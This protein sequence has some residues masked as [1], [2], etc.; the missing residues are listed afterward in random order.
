MI[1]II[2]GTGKKTNYKHIKDSDPQY[3]KY[4]KEHYIINLKPE[5]VLDRIDNFGC[6][7]VIITGGEPMVQHKHLLRLLQLMKLSKNKYS[8]EMETNG[9]LVPNKELDVLIDQ[10]N[11]S[12]KLSN[13]HVE[14]K[15]RLIPNSIRFFSSSSKANFKF[16]VDNESD[17]NEILS[18]QR[19]FEIP[20]SKI[21]LMPQGVTSESLRNKQKWLVE[22]CKENNFT[23]T[24]RLH[25]HIYGGKRGV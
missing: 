13:S 22:I 6:S 15:H 18:L 2:H 9:T 19:T 1:L 20:S 8:V 3:K 12:I 7:N 5:E 23:Y 24:D 21:L 4:K 14:E 10:Y 11:V 25:I 17:L 16:V